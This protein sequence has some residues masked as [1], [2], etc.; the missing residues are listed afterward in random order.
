[1]N[2]I[3]SYILERT[4]TYKGETYRV[5]DNG[6]V[7]RQPRPEGRPRKD[8]SIWTFGEKNA[9]NG[10]MYIGQQPCRESTL[11]YSPRKCI[12]K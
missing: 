3:N 8:D 9:T 2:L 4:C 12:T 7:Y 11:A 1:M 6:A 10:Y 5:R